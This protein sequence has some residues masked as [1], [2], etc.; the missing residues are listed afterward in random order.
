MCKETLLGLSD[1]AV[2]PSILSQTSVSSRCVDKVEE[3]EEIEE[4]YTDLER[5]LA[6]YPLYPCLWGRRG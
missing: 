2:E 5:F 3:I 1:A 4:A 6:Y